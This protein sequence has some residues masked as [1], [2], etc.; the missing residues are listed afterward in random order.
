MK[1]TIVSA[2]AAICLA[3]AVRVPAVAETSRTVKEETVY[4]ILSASGEVRNVIVS[5]KLHSLA[6]GAVI[7][8]Q[9]ALT[10]IVNLQSDEKPS[11]SGK[12][13][14][15][16]PKGQDV[17]YQGKTAETPPI[18]FRISYFLDGKPVSANAI[19]GKSG[20]VKIVVKAINRDAH[21]VTL[22]GIAREVKTPFIT[23]VL[24]ALPEGT[25]TNVEVS[26]NGKALGDGQSD[27]ILGIMLPGMT[28]SIEANP[29]LYRAL[30]QL[31]I[32]SVVMPDTFTITAITK[33]FKLGPMFMTASP[34][35]TSVLPETGGAAKKTGGIDAA[36]LGATLKV[37]AENG[38]RLEVGVAALADGSD[39]LREGIN[40]IW[41]AAAAGLGGT[42]DTGDGSRDSMNA[43]LAKG[44]SL[45][46]DDAR[47]ESARRL[48]GDA[49]YLN[50][51]DLSF[52]KSL[53][54]LLDKKNARLLAKTLED[55]NGLDLSGLVNMP[56]ASLIVSDDNVKNLAGALASSDKFYAGINQKD[57]DRTKELAAA[58]AIGLDKPLAAATGA[59]QD[60]AA[61]AALADRIVAAQGLTDAD[62]AAL[63]TLVGAVPEISAAGRYFA[64]ENAAFVASV[65]DGVTEQKAVHDKNRANYAMATSLLRMI[66]RNGGFR[67]TIVKLDALQHDLKDLGPLAGELQ[68]TLDSGSLR[69]LGDPAE[70]AKKLVEMGD[71]LAANRDL[72]VMAEELL[73]PESVAKER[74]IAEKLPELKEGVTAIHDG[75]NKLADG[76]TELSDKT[77]TFNEQGIQ[78]LAT[79]LGSVADILANASSATQELVAL[80]RKYTSFSGIG[81][82][83]EGHVKFIMR[84]EE[85]AAK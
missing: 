50:S 2:L 3:G 39:K 61:R 21:T 42:G 57:V 85:I 56:F 5:D 37:F 63:M 1:K 32:A 35:I 75:A 26:A 76:M 78:V 36:G 20:K 80:S 46:M 28:Q 31:G 77:A 38:D 16:N 47:I 58:T 45:I 30:E 40:A 59:L 72:V 6:A 17:Y 41:D 65:M 55:A 8:D 52:I 64:P 27:V 66:E 82:N 29:E 18:E 79:K 68:T 9:S 19:A 70:L 33:S 15:W 84:T 13:V 53:P 83:M 4:A 14:T 43:M 74:A 67:K 49:E 44:M 62:K 71:D 69:K 25:F 7:R 54:D 48:M 12:N 11:I 60:E 51:L 24:L 23:A 22:N 10:D 34:D 73:K 81:D